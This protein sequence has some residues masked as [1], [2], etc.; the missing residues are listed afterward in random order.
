MNILRLLAIFVVTCVALAF[1][2][3][4]TP[5]SGERA[6]AAY[7]PLKSV[8]VGNS[9]VFLDTSVR[10]ALR[11]L[12]TGSR[13]TTAL[14]QLAGE[15]FKQLIARSAQFVTGPRLMREMSGD[16]ELAH[17]Q[18]LVRAEIRETGDYASR[19]RDTMETLEQWGVGDARAWRRGDRTWG[20][21]RDKANQ[22]R[23][24]V[25]EALLAEREGDEIPTLLT[26][27]RIIAERLF[28]MKKSDEQ[29][30]GFRTQPG[31][32]NASLRDFTIKVGGRKLRVLTVFAE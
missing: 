15:R 12:R 6:P 7:T 4:A 29:A 18:E 24:I 31:G 17:G 21:A 25:T 30:K 5:V 20:A 23:E 3:C 2:A 9:H 26:A 1:A 28:L 10:I 22:D 8:R 13:E 16:R 27:D 32:I 14:D 19:Y 11:N